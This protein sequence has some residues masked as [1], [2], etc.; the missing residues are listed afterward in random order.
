VAE[1][2]R[3]DAQKPGLPHAVLVVLAIGFTSIQSGDL[4][5][6]DVD[7]FWNEDVWDWSDDRLR[8][9]YQQHK[10]AVDAE[11]ARRGVKPWAASLR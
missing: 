10:A 2:F 5:D 6:D 4:T 1:K 3:R 7:L 8:E 11:A 9:L